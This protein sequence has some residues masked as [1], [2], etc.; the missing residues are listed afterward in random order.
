VE[1]LRELCAQNRARDSVVPD[2]VI[3]RMLERC[4]VPEVGEAHDVSYAV[5]T[6]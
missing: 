5:R 4:E 1:C 3:E 2:G 6:G